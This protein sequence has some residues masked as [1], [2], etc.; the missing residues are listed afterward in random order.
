MTRSISRQLSW[1]AAAVVAGGGGDAVRAREAVVARPDA[2]GRARGAAAAELG[3][4][5]GA[6][7]AGTVRLLFAACL[8]GG[9]GGGGRGRGRVDGDSID[10]DGRT[11]LHI[12]PPATARGTYVAKWYGSKVFV[13]ILDRDTFSD[14]D[15]IGAF[16]KE[17]T[18]L[19]KAR[20]PNLV[21]FVGAVTQS[22]PMMVVSEYHQQMGLNYLHECKPDP[23]IHGNLS[24]KNIVRDDEGKLKVAGFGSLSLK[25]SDDKVE[26]DRPVTSCENMIEGTPAFH[27]KPPEEAVKMIC[28][29]GLRPPLFKNKPK[30]YPDGVKEVYAT[31]LGSETFRQAIVFRDIC[32]SEQDIH[33]LWETDSLERHL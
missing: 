10:L 15:S 16:K 21:Q 30:C 2:A 22:V 6:G 14:A 29:E 1:G 19:E 11:P 26:M 24:T 18:L 27:P 3:V 4:G 32:S 33:K 7:D 23:I 25:V 9:G 13:K 12:A 5:V 17:L 28:L 8:G 20:H 31:M